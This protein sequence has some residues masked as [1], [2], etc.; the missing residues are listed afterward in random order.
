[1]KT[2]FCYLWNSNV[3]HFDL[4]IGHTCNTRV[5]SEIYTFSIFDLI[6]ADLSENLHVLNVSSY[7]NL[8]PSWNAYNSNNIEVLFEFAYGFFTDDTL[9]LLFLLVL[10]MVRNDIRTYAP[11]C[12]FALVNDWWVINKLPL[13]LPTYTK[14]TIHSYLKSSSIFFQICVDYVCCLIL[15]Q[16]IIF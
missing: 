8:I 9:F 15:W 2:T 16:I 10:K 5:S 13:C 6:V 3:F 12:A 4:L 11:S 7:P 1:M 14:L